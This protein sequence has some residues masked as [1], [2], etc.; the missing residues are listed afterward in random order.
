V[1]R[2]DL[3]AFDAPPLQC[4]TKTLA[5]TSTSDVLRKFGQDTMLVASVALSLVLVAAAVLGCE[6]LVQT[7]SVCLCVGATDQL[8]GT[9]LTSSTPLETSYCSVEIP[10]TN[11]SFHRAPSSQ[12]NPIDIQ[13]N[14]S[15]RSP[16]PVE[17]LAGSKSKSPTQRTSMDHKV[18]DVKIRLLMLVV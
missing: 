14:T 3:T 7:K 1:G 18:A 2:E 15:Q 13:I 16:E 8:G 10:A 11:P 17:E 4:G 9:Q 5:L 6:E 12:S